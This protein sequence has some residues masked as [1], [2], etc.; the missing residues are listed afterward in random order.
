M[1]SLADGHCERGSSRAG[2]PDV[3]HVPK[4]GTYCNRFYWSVRAVNHIFVIRHM[5]NIYKLNTELKNLVN[6]IIHGKSLNYTSKK[7]NYILEAYRVTSL[8]RDVGG[9]SFP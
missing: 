1:V 6:I 5:I 9:A 7:S 8:R 4:G 3:N 2:N